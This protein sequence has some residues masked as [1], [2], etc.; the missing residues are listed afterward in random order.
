MVLENSFCTICGHQHENISDQE[1]KSCKIHYVK[2]NLISKSEQIDKLI[3]EIRLK[4]N[5]SSDVIFEWI[6]YDQ[7]Y[8]II[9]TRND[10]SVALWKNGPLQYDRYKRKFSRNKYKRVALKYLQDV[11]I[12]DKV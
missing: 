8:N 11:I 3:Q 7:F 5:D 1:C 2:P 12:K 6:P 10:L 9:E 4:I